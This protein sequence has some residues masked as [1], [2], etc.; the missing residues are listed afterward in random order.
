MKKYLFFLT[1][2]LCAESGFIAQKNTQIVYKEIDGIT[3]KMD[4]YYPPDIG[5]QDLYPAMVYFFGGGWKKNSK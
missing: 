5:T 4:I 2:L 3:L 1:L